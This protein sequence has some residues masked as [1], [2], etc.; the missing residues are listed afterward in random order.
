MHHIACKGLKRVSNPLELKL[1]MVVSHDV[2]AGDQSGFS[3][4]VAHPLS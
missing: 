4:S 3:R 2:G 1:Q